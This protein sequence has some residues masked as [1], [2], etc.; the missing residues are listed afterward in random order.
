MERV[1]SLVGVFDSIPAKSSSSNESRT[2]R[3]ASLLVGEDAVRSCDI[4]RV[5]GLTAVE[6]SIS[7][8]SSSSKESKMSLSTLF[9]AAR[10]FLDEAAVAGFCDIERVRGL[11]DPTFS[12]WMLWGRFCDLKRVSDLVDVDAS[13]S[14]K[15]SS[16]KDF[17]AFFL[18]LFVD[19]CRDASSCDTKRVLGL[20]ALVTSL[21]DESMISFRTCFFFV[22]RVVFDDFKRVGGLVD[23]SISTSSSFSN[24]STTFS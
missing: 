8:K 2:T 18:A 3:C 5:E 23:V 22:P 19:R 9:V 11:A 15:S 24:A 14:T 17:R 4:K 16:S 21:S 7:A 12:R 6:H 1:R 20:N 13:I 10:F